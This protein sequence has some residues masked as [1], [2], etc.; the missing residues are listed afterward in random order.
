MQRRRYHRMGRA[1]LMLGVLSFVLWTWMSALSS[2]FT[3]ESSPSDRPVALF[4]AIYMGL[5]LLHGLVCFRLRDKRELSV[6]HIFFWGLVFRLVFVTS[7]PILETDYYRYIW[8]GYVVSRGANPYRHSPL[9]YARKVSQSGSG[10]D[11]VVAAP[12]LSDIEEISR[13]ETLLTVLRR[14]NHPEE[15][16]IYPI[17]AQMY[18][19]GHWFVVPADPSVKALMIIFSD[20][21]AVDRYGALLAL[22]TVA[23][24][25]GVTPMA[26]PDLLVEP[27]GDSRG[28]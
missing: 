19:A 18:F 13:N 3:H 6:G 16:T 1:E 21:L 14:V 20:R 2:S 17:L 24:G 15:K 22:S 8:D 26:G 28:A 23:F 9:D 12:E 11:F 5:F 25:S 4:V 27:G 7:V 10:K